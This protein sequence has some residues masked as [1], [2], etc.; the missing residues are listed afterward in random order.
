MGD[1]NITTNVTDNTINAIREFSVIKD[2][3]RPIEDTGNAEGRS[4]TRT[5]APCMLRTT[6]DGEI[7][8]DT[9]AIK[10]H[11]DFDGSMQSKSA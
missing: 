6:T 8:D 7:Y 3:P 2:Q 5:A 9:S 1:S 10:F 11:Y 4:R